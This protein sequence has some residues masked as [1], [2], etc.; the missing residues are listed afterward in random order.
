VMRF[1]TASQCTERGCRKGMTVEDKGKLYIKILTEQ[2]ARALVER[3]VGEDIDLPPPGYGMVVN[4]DF[5][6]CNHEG[7]YELASTE[8]FPQEPACRRCHDGQGRG[9]APIPTHLGH[10]PR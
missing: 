3:E 9:I 4:D 8:P 2:E 5:T 1:D 7:A 6:L 10:V